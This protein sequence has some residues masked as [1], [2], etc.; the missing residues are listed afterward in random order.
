MTELF[1]ES[2]RI[3]DIE[4]SD[5]RRSIDDES[6]GNLV[7]SILEIGLLYPITI[8]TEGRL[9]AGYH[10]LL[11]YRQLNR[12]EIP[13][14]RVNLDKLQ[15][16]LAE[17]DENLIRNE[18]TVIDRG[19]S[20]RRRKE[21]YELIY[22]ETKAG[23]AGGKG[24]RVT[25]ADSAPVSFTKDAAKKT[26]RSER[27]VQEDIQI[28]T[29]LAPDVKTGIKGTELADRK[30]DLLR[31]SQMPEEKQREVVNKIV[32]GEAKSFVDATRKVRKDELRETPP[33]DGMFR[34]ILADPPWDYAQVIDKYGP[35]ER[36]YPTM[37]TPE[38]CALKIKTSDGETERAIR[39]ITEENA[40]L[41]LWVTSPKVEE[42]FQVAKAW[43]FTYKAM[44]VWDKVKH[45]WGHYN[46]VRHELLLICTKGGCT[47]DSDELI[48]SVQSIER[49]D[50]HSEKPAEFREI[51]DSMYTYGNKVE[52][53]ARGGLPENWVGWGNEVEL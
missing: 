43:G 1:V 31:L 50:E 22:P 24:N 3:D 18:L 9:V 26:G 39:D 6:L 19:E 14:I 4:I 53:F 5:N 32:S 36:H 51:I 30:T 15:A 41:F 42:G 33:I 23:V 34:I 47:P 20:L 8:T 40:V 48:D 2:V 29:N 38:I 46:S 49:S 37:P 12:E 27:V 7:D 10:R 17:I 44:F 21:I 16:E 11:A 52:L 45:N 28:A 13:A 25:S 35:A